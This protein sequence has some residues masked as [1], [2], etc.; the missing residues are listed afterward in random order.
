L[1]STFF[2]FFREP[3]PFVS[4]SLKPRAGWV[5]GAGPL[6]PNKAPRL[7]PTDVEMA[8]PGPLRQSFFDRSES[9][10]VDFAV[11]IR[12]PA[13]EIGRKQNPAIFEAH[14]IF[15]PAADQP[16]TKRSFP[17]GSSPAARSSSPSVGDYHAGRFHAMKDVCPEERRLFP[18]NK[19]RSTAERS[20]L[21]R[22]QQAAKAAGGQE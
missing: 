18:V 15:A 7:R 10:G 13:G 4:E 12:P 20:L 11:R 14:R 19:S 9:R 3:A 21:Y 8:S 17:A 6:F 5:S 22:Q 2:F 1:I 16:A